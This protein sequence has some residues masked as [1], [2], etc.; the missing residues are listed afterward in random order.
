MVTGKF[1]AMAAFAKK[2]SDEFYG[3]YYVPL[4]GG[5]LQP[6]QLFYPSYYNS[7][8]VRLY[9]FDGKEVSENPIVI[10]W[11]RTL[12]QEGIWVNQITGSWSFP[13][14][15]EAE[16]YIASQESGNYKIVSQDPFVSPVPLEKME[17]YS[18]VYNSSQLAGDNPF[19]KIF[20][21]TE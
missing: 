7:T 21:Y 6:V 16:A 17:H 15:E 20:E 1:Y 2:S 13:S 10:S 5:T 11:Q 9:N 3:F 8:V 18:L 12:V 4:E 14:Y 19:I